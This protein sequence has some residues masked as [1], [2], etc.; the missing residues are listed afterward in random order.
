MNI[1]L[2]LEKLY[3]FENVE[4]VMQ[5][6]GSNKTLKI[7][8]LNKFNRSKETSNNFSLKLLLHIFIWIYC[9]FSD[10]FLIYIVHYDL[11]IYLKG[12]SET[13]FIIGILAPK[14]FKQISNI[15]A[16]TKIIDFDSK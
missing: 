10:I 2:Y 8:R 11:Y 14:G 1:Y 16:N 15:Y 7:F 4:T 13:K 3:I 9:L 12:S 5:N 6:L